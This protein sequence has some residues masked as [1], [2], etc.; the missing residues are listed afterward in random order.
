LGLLKDKRIGELNEDQADL[1]GDI[2]QATE[3]L[4]T[5]TGEILQL[6][7]IES[8]KIKINLQAVEVDE[9]VNYTLQA[10]KVSAEQKLLCV[11]ATTAPNLPVFFADIDKIKWVVINFLTNAIHYAP[12]KSEVKLSIYPDDKGIIFSVSDKGKGISEMYH[13]KIFEKYF[14]VPNSDR[15]IDKQG[16]GLGLAICREFIEA[17]KGEIWVESE[18]NKGSTFFFWLPLDI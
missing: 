17:H 6:S 18:I 1:L 10:I 15:N 9:L 7:Q 3:R 13:L 4:F 5:L 2:E 8:G 14:Q 16:T 11:E 12:Q